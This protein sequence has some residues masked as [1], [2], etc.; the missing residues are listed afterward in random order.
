[1]VESM[2]FVVSVICVVFNSIYVD[3]KYNQISLP[4]TAGSLCLCGVSSHV[5]VFGLSVR[6][7]LYPMWWVW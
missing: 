4:F 7:S 3:L 2:C 6:L 5:V 1:M